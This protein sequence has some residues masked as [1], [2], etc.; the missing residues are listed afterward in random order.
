[1]LSVIMLNVVMLSVIM[2]SVVMLSVVMLSV[3]KLSVVAPLEMN[4][5]KSVSILIL[6]KKIQLMTYKSPIGIK[7]RKGTQMTGGTSQRC[8]LK[9][10]YNLKSCS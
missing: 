2:L 7:E 10:D 1:M 8:H 6:M 9:F 5:F 4:S 3:I